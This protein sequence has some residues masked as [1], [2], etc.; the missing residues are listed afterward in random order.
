M[1]KGLEKPNPFRIFTSVNNDKNK[2]KPNYYEKIKKRSST[3][4]ENV[5][6][7]R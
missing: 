2:Q 4:Q 1:R 5:K 3:R 7:N 6:Q